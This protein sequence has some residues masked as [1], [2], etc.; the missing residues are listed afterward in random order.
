MKIY[1]KERAELEFR[2]ALYRHKF[3]RAWNN[4]ILRA[5]SDHYTI[6]GALL[7]FTKT[8]SSA[9]IYKENPLTLSNNSLEYR[10]P[11]D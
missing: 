1:E 3:N 8:S 7:E 11:E 9:D 2:K 10:I 4:D 6:M 5:E